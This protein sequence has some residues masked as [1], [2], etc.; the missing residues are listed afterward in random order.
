MIVW[1]I[2]TLSFQPSSP[3]SGIIAHLTSQF[4]GNI[5]DRGVVTI[6]ANRPISNYPSYAAKN[7][8][9]L[10]TDSYF[11]SANEPNQW[12]CFDFKAMKIRPT[13]YSVR[14]CSG[15]PNTIHLKNWVI[16]GSADGT[17]WNEIDR[18]ENNTDLNNSYAV[19]TFNVCRV[20]TFQMIRL[21]QIGLNHQNYNHLIFTAFE[22]FGSL[23][24]LK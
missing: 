19:K 24:G 8:A 11:R 1:Q 16:E 14:T 9:D 17:S 20:D 23:I 13:H 2:T 21:R 5:H 18:R 7:V 22:L 4:S 15:G 10:G 6:T 3:L 12:I